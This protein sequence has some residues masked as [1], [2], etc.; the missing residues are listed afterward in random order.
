M[1]KKD[2]NVGIYFICDEIVSLVVVCK[3]TLPSQ[4]NYTCKALKQE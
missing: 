2:R 3:K 1:Q 4:E